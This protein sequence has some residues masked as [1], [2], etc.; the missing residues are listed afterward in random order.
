MA[1]APSGSAQRFAIANGV[2]I[3][4]GRDGELYV[5][6][7]IPKNK[8]LR[9]VRVLENSSVALLPDDAATDCWNVAHEKQGTLHPN[10]KPTELAAR[11]IRNSS[12][13]G[14]CVYDPFGGAGFTIMAAESLGRFAFTC[15]LDPKFVA[16]MLE[17]LSETGLKP[18]LTSVEKAAS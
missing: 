1:S 9:Q 13:P 16:V 8:K 7:R 3:L 14:D 15:E 12:Q 2:H 11:A 6:A 10:Q 4:N 17:R 18:K 5:T